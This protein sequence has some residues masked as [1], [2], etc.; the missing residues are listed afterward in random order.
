MS[1]IGG[2]IAYARIAS[3]LTQDQLAKRIG[4]SKGA[5]SQWETGLIKGLTA[6]NLMK[7]A[8]AVEASE[9]WIM[10]G[11]DRDGRDIPMGRP[12]HLDPD[13]ADLIQTYIQLPEH[14]RDELRSDAHKYLRITAPQQATKAN[15]YPRP[16]KKPK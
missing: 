1:T 9:R 7:L 3:G 14:V 15:P 5:I 13:A 12:M 2:R 4:V 11:K 6:E 8:D 16:V 10:M